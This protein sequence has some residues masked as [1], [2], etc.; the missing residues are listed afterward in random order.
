MSAASAAATPAARNHRLRRRSDSSP[1][2]PRTVSASPERVSRTKTVSDQANDASRCVDLAEANQRLALL[3]GQLERL[4]T[5]LRLTDEGIWCFEFDPPVPLSTQIDQA[6]GQEITGRDIGIS[7]G[8]F[9]VDAAFQAG[10]VHF[11]FWVQKER[12]GK[13]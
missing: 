9:L 3:G 5:F 10:K 1:A 12:N 4:R 7:F 8:T 11:A 2:S 13:P 6:L